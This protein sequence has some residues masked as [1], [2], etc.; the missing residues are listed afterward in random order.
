VE[1][2]L[3]VKQEGQVHK[4]VAQDVYGTD[5]SLSA[6]TQKLVP[7]FEHRPLD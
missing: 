2:A 4:T 3:V 7:L 6:E 5:S 1:K